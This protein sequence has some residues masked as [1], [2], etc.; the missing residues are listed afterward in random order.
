VRYEEHLDDRFRAG[1]DDALR[2]AYHR[3]ARAVHHLAAAQL[4]SPPDAEDVTQAVFVAAWQRRAAFD[5]DRGTLLGWLMGITRRKI[6]DH[7]RERGRRIRINEA[8]SRF[9]FAPSGEADDA[10]RL[11]RRLV[12]AD[13]M[14]RLPDAERRLLTLAFY[15]DLSHQQIAAVTN[16]PL[17]TVKS[18]LR[19]GLAR[20]RH[21]WEMDGGTGPGLAH[22]ARVG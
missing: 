19:R 15:E 5:P 3:F 18:H 13:A 10:D 9:G 12:V 11:V 6:I 17:G 1:D 2:E 14:N 21:R 8:A 16:L 20:L 22:A 4:A 7:L